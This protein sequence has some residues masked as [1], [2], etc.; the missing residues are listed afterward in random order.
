M[1]ASS[2]FASGTLLAVLAAVAFGV[3]APMVQAAGVGV[4]AFATAGLLYSG[5]TI[6]AFA[7][8]G[9]RATPLIGV[10]RKHSLR[11]LTVA[12]FGATLAPTLFA[13]GLQHSGA[14]S[15]SLLLNMEAVFT[16]GLAW[17]LLREPIG[18]RVAL[19]LVLMTSGG[20]ALSIQHAADFEWQALGALAVVAATFCWSCDNTLSRALSEESPLQVVVVKSGA[21]AV[22]STLMAMML[23]NALP[24]MTRALSLLACGAVGYGV[25]LGFYLGAQ[26]RIGAARTGSTF[27]IAPFI[28]AATSWLWGDR[29]LGTVA[30]ASAGLFAIGV[31]LHATER[32]SHRHSHEP[33]E[34]SHAHRHDD[35]HHNH[36][37]DPPVVGEHEHWHQ[38]EAL[39]HEHAHAPDIH[40]RHSH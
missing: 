18:R 4:G 21:G 17:V 35:G 32:H 40:H 38:H 31:Y 39:E 11:L 24:S 19:A 27:A 2:P 37:H 10:G 29:E 23:G 6:A 20:I 3:T 7:L 9:F 28:G 26:R 1:A 36:T 30:G 16:V 5:A 8:D 12:L 15:A 13:W 14:T 25:S 34:H 22:L 33:L